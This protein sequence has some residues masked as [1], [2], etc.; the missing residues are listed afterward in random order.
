[1]QGGV[2]GLDTLLRRCSTTG[3]SLLDHRIVAARP[4]DAGALGE[5]R[6]SASVDWRAW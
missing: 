6:G 4:P 1:M 2:R 3:S 5:F